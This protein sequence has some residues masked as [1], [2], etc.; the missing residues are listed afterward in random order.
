MV[1]K[2][3]SLLIAPGS[4]PWMEAFVQIFKVLAC[5]MGLDLGR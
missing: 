5:D 1:F 3:L 4:S 2:E